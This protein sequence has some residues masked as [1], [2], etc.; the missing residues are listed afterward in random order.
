M[1]HVARGMMCKVLSDRHHCISYM[2]GQPA[3][4]VCFGML[5]KKLNPGRH[6]FFKIFFACMT[7][8]QVLSAEDF[9]HQ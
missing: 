8:T 6:I 1:L 4:N 2:W 5:E 3:W 9:L 7:N